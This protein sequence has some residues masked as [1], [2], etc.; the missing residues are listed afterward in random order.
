MARQTDV[1]FFFDRDI[2]FMSLLQAL[3]DTGWN[4][5]SHGKI[6]YLPGDIED[7]DWMDADL[8][9]L[10]QVFKEL[11]G[12]AES[13][14]GGEIIM[15]WQDT[16]SGGSLHF[17]PK[18]G[19]NRISFSISRNRKLLHGHSEFYGVTDFSWYIE[20]LI[21]AFKNINLNVREVKIG[22]LY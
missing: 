7:I 11:R 3:V 5:N 17:G 20:R 6:V 22:Y 19:R 18:F 14:D 2:D 10:P 8:D 15:V 1:F 12:S 13:G 9:N 4:F 21:P 16:M